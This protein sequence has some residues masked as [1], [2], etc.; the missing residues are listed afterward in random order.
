MAEVLDDLKLK[1]AEL[2][3]AGQVANRIIHSDLV[4]LGELGYRPFSLSGD[5]LLFQSLSSF[6]LRNSSAKAIKI[7]KQKAPTRPSD[8]TQVTSTNRDNFWRQ[9]GV[10]S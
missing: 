1:I 10:R 2:A 7:N 6:W 9:S 5:A 8:Q 3:C 4:T